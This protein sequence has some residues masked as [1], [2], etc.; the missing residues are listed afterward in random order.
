MRKRKNRGTGV[1]AYLHKLGLLDSGSDEELSI[2][3]ETYWKQYKANWIKAKRKQTNITVFL[4]DKELRIVKI[5]AKANKRSNTRYLKEAALAY[6][7]M[8]YLVPDS[9]FYLQITGIMDS[10]IAL[11]K[12]VLHTGITDFGKTRQ[13]FEEFLI[14]EEQLRK[15]LKEPSQ[16]DSEW[17]KELIKDEAKK[18]YILKLIQAA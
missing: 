13:S 3:R 7:Q 17:F 2:A 6:A 10:I 9:R 14:L 5:A 12:S 8:L 18:E 1:Y 4:S 15:I 16:L 11:L